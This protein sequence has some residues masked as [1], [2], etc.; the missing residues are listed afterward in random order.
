MLYPAFKVKLI[1]KDLF[2]YVKILLKID[3]ARQFRDLEL[4]FVG[5][6]GDPFGAVFLKFSLPDH[7]QHG[8]IQF[9]ALSCILVFQIALAQF[10]LD[11]FKQ[12]FLF[13]G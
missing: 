2:G 12:L 3:I 10:L 11:K 8:G 6:L 7:L 1:Q 9:F 5:A 4:G 13:V